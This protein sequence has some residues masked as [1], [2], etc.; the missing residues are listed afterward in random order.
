MN[1]IYKGRCPEKYTKELIEMLD[2]VFFTDDPNNQKFITLLPKLYKDKYSPAYNNVVVMEGEEIKG[3]VG[4]YP[5]NAVAAG[6]KLK[7]LG[8]GNVAV[9]TDCRGKGYM[10]DTMQMA[11]NIMSEEKFDYSLLGGQRQRYGFFGYEPIGLEYR[12]LIDNGNIRR[13]LGKLEK[14]GFTAREITEKDADIIKKI[15]VLHEELPFF[16]ERKEEDYIDILH[17]WN[18]IPYAAFEG[19]EFK[20]YFTLE[21]HGG[22]YLHEIRAVDIN[23]M[24]KLIMCAME[25]GNLE[26]VAINL[27]AFDTEYCDFMAKNCGGYSIGTPEMINIFNFRNFID[28]FLALKA[29]RMN[30]ASGTLKILIHGMNGDE[31]LAVTVDGNNVTVAQADGNADI[32]LD[33]NQAI[34]FI[35]GLYSKERLGLPDFAQGWFPLDFFSYSLDNV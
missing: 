28:A 4:C 31:F 20:G 34:V 18:N 33:H 2:T 11:L 17:S 32:E 30:L 5:L 26:G 24:L 6:R 27:P 1:N 12:F 23:D 16:V 19:D 35:S 7:I 10:K 25:T 22:K 9:T 3:A 21:K 13:I 14:S 29:Q 8:I 15:K